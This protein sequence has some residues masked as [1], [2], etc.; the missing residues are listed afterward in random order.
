MEHQQSQQYYGVLIVDDDTPLREALRFTLED[1]GY[2]VYEA[3]DGTV[4]REVLRSTSYPLVVLLDYMMPGMTGMELLY[5]VTRDVYLLNRHVFILMS[6]MSTLLPESLRSLL[7]THAI[8]VV[9]KPFDLDALLA[10]LAQAHDTIL[11][12]GSTHHE[13]HVGY[14]EHIEHVGHIGHECP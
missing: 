12:R 8:P 2:L 4:A 6:A 9:G 5:E 7:A 10:A 3:P 13:G 14:I 1:A 11:T